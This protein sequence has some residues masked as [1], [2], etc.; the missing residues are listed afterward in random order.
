MA[1]TLNIYEQNRLLYTCDLDGVMELGRQAELHEPLYS[2]VKTQDTQPFWRVVIA[3]HT[4]RNVSRSHARLE[5]LP[6]QSIRVTNVSTTQPLGLPYESNPIL[7]PGGSREL[8]VGHSTLLVLGNRSV[9]VEAPAVIE[10]AIQNP[11]GAA[12]PG[13]AWDD[14]PVVTESAMQKLGKITPVPMSPTGKPPTDFIRIKLTP[15]GANIESIVRWMQ[16]VIGVLQSATNS[17]SFFQ[18]A[19]KS[20]VDL[21]GLDAG[22]VLLL[23]NG[24]WKT[25]AAASCEESPLGAVGTPSQ[26]VLTQVRSER[27]TFWKMPDLTESALGS[28]AGVQAVV[29]A[30]ILDAGGNV[31]GA[32][33]GDRR[34]QVGSLR[35]P[36]ISKHEAMLV[37]LLSY[38]VA[39]GL[40]RL[41]QEKAALKAVGQF[42]QFFTP[43]LSRQLEAQP[44]LLKG[45]DCE[46]SVLFC[47]IRGF[48][49][50]GSQVPAATMLDMMNDVLGVLSDC[51]LAHGGVL[52]D[53]IG[54]ELMAMWGAPEVQTDHARRASQAALDMLA[55]LP[56]LNERWSATLPLPL[57]LG[58]GISSGPAR[59]GNSGSY[60]KFKYG[61]VGNVVNLGSRVQGATKFL[62]TRLLVTGS[63][64]AALD[65]SIHT[66]SLC[67]VRMVNIDGPVEL[68]EI[69]TPDRMGWEELKQTYE[70]ALA[71]FDRR[72][73][74]P[75]ARAL[76]N[77]RFRFPD[78]GPSLVMLSR[79]VNAMVEES[80]TFDPVWKLPGK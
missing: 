37:E 65:A 40:A 22:R 52:V 80:A 33:Y 62:K 47:D 44:D 72:D 24:E 19:A 58:I 46:V 29:A 21:V 16:A 20:I 3:P 74:G 41:E 30:P 66:R 71:A 61:P 8:A 67:R 17:T 39:T 34:F 55:K 28:L 64:A 60:R 56:N 49:K 23:E 50:M 6:G 53:Y 79:V 31:I 78:D 27:S 5:V 51:V 4:E 25:V 73:F 13:F 45:R 75:A 26:Q 2:K 68:C 9:R 69:F 48:S 32:L 14:D 54:D 7:A 18:E 36:E 42:E 10:P 77:L 59:V 11:G 63:T 70:D 15:D 43:E 57:D 12:R 35:P 76:S 1:L 38:S